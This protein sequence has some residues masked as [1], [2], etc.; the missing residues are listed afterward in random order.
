MQIVDNPVLDQLTDENSDL[1]T[2]L[3]ERDE[4]IAH[5][6]EQIAWFK[7]QIFG[8]RSERVVSDLNAFQMLLEG[9]ENPD[10]PKEPEKKDIPGHKRKKPNRNGQDA[11]TLPADLPV[12]TTI[13][14]IPEEEK[15]CK[16]SGEPLV[17]IGI[18]VTHKLAHKPGSYY[19]K[20]IIR[21]KY[22]HPQK[23]EFGV[24]YAELPDSIIPKCRADESLLAEIIT[25]KFADHLPLYRIAEIMGREK[26]KISRKLLSQWVVRVGMTLKPLYD[27]MTKQILASKNVFIDETPVKLQDQVKCKQAYIWVM[28]G[29]NEADPPYRV[30]DFREDR[31][32]DNVIDMLKGYQGVLHS[33]KYAAYENLAKRKII[34]WCPCWSHIRRYFFDAEAGDPIFRKWVLR[35]IRYLFMLERVAWARS[36]E[37]RLKIR[38]EKE[39]PIINELTQKIKAKLLDNTILPKSKLRVAIG[40]FCGLIPYLKNYTEYAFARLDN[41]VAE[42]AVRPLAIGR[43]NWLFFGSPDGGEAGAILFSLVQTCRNLGINPREYLE[44]LFRRFMEHPMKNLPELLPD[45]WLARKKQPSI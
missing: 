40:Y 32:H 44:D 45:Q 11:I 21:P 24:V 34:T 36:P 23:E 29:G 28:V 26:I 39:V 17:Q 35:K 6:N 41:N 3:V 30:Y 33:D 9:F 16:E 14:D 12:E 22:A 1:K 42:R 31:G 13:L 38:Q 27:E 19:V 20:E 5:L 18:E 7:R 37:E 10:A 15:I 2:K 25:R 43:K 4:K 8:K